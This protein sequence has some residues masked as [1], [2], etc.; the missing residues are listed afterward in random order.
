[1]WKLIKSIAA[2]SWGSTISPRNVRQIVKNL[3]LSRDFQW[4]MN[5]TFRT[6]GISL[7]EITKRSKWDWLWTGFGLQHRKGFDGKWIGQ[8]IGSASVGTSMETDIQ[9]SQR[10]RGSVMRQAQK[11]AGSWHWH[12]CYWAP[13]F[14]SAERAFIDRFTIHAI[15]FRYDSDC[16]CSRW[17]IDGD[18]WCAFVGRHTHSSV[19]FCLR[20]TRKRIFQGKILEITK[21]K[22]SRSCR[23]ITW[24]GQQRGTGD[25]LIDFLSVSPPIRRRHQQQLWR[26]LHG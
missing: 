18:I 26:Q 11:C 1:M 23:C 25:L 3:V 2:F 15:E 10:R 14:C 17:H 20:R 19:E 21:S 12:H 5:W 22:A 7:D 24:L 9:K 13:P 6:V 8:R 4:T 16:L